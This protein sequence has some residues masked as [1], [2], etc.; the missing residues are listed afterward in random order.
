M[1]ST[2][3]Q[4][5]QAF[6]TQILD[7]IDQNDPLFLALKNFLSK[8]DQTLPPNKNVKLFLFG[9]MLV[10]LYT[11]L[12][13]S[14]Y[15]EGEFNQKVYVSD[16]LNLIY[17]TDTGQERQIRFNKND[18]SRFNLIHQ[19]YLQDAQIIPFS[20]L[21]NM[22]VYALSPVDVCVS[23]IARLSLIDIEDV[24]LLV[25]TGLCSAQNIAQRAKEA[26]NDYVGDLSQFH[27]NLSLAIHYANLAK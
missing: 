13:R 25:K 20:H 22:Q 1:T 4:I 11:G 14:Y 6:M 23:K 5:T 3:N 10:Y 17:T 15:I 19:N 2:D 8:I 7:N 26:S 18:N 21:N 24:Q 27:T 9:G 12:E 16:G